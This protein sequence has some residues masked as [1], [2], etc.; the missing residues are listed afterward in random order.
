[1]TTDVQHA[2]DIYT[3][4]KPTAIREAR[5]YVMNR[6]P[7]H[8]QDEMAH[9]IDSDLPPVDPPTVIDTPAL[10]QTGTGVGSTL[11]CTLGNWNGE[12]TSR[13]YQ[14]KKAGTNVGTS[15][16]TYTLVTGDPGALFTCTM[17]ATNGVGSSAPVTSSPI[18]AA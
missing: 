16:P 9:I 13:T 1:M 10:S 5:N 3:K 11:N 17:V 15:S 14:W 18:L 6:T 7:H 4:L 8:L 12:P 2:Q